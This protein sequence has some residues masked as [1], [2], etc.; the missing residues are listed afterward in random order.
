MVGRFINMDTGTG[1]DVEALK[2]GY[3]SVVPVTIDFTDRK[4]KEWLEKEWQ[5]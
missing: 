5:F 4:A 1:T 2:E 3:A